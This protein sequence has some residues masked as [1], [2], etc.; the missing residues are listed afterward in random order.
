MC[1]SDLCRLQPER[2][3]VDRNDNV[4]R[5]APG[6][7]TSPNLPGRAKACVLR[8]L[9][10]GAEGVDR[11]Q[12]ALG[13]CTVSDTQ[14][15][16]AIPLIHVHCLAESALSRPKSVQIVHNNE[17][18]IRLATGRI[19]SAR[20]SDVPARAQPGPG[21]RLR[22]GEYPCCRSGGQI[23]GGLNSILPGRGVTTT[24]VGRPARRQSAAAVSSFAVA[25]W[26][27]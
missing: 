26:M 15:P 21:N 8:W 17:Q 12:S 23:S 14:L 2:R 24:P 1:S 18:G 19:G 7:R 5:R 13:A 6:W 4:K 25:S 27:A 3:R 16:G 9:Y 11:G 20:Q 10:G 22:V